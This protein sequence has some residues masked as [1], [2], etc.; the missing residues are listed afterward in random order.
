MHTVWSKALH[1]SCDTARHWKRLCP[2]SGEESARQGSGVPDAGVF[3][4]HAIISALAAAA[5]ARGARIV[6]GVDVAELIVESGSVSGVRVVGE[7]AIAADAV[8]LC[9]GAW[10]QELGRLSGVPLPLTPLR[11]HLVQ[12]QPSAPWPVGSPTVWRIEDDVY[13]RAES[14]GVLASPCDEDVYPACDPPV[15]AAAL[16]LLAAKLQRSAPGLA[17]AAVQRSWACLRTFAPDRELVAGPDPRLAGLHWLGGLGGRGLSVALAAAEFAVA[18][19][20]DDP[21]PARP[22]MSPSRLL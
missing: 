8:V 6:T 10:G 12:L 11:R 14:G 17:D 4:P 13:F 16:E 22:S 21:G 9:A 3:D 5:Q 20:L 1:A 19:L 18:E 2:L 15:D 7:P